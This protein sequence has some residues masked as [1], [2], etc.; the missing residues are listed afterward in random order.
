MV[1]EKYTEFIDD[2]TLQVKNNIIPMSRIDDA[3]KRILRVKFVMGLFENPL[4]DTSLVKELGSQ[5]HR[6]LAKEA[7]RKS[8]VLLKNG[9]P[10]AKPLLPL[11]KKAP[12]ILVAGSHA[13]NLG[14]QCGGWTIQWQGVSGNDVTSGM[15]FYIYISHFYIKHFTHLDDIQ[16]W[17][18]TEN[19]P[20]HQRCGCSYGTQVICSRC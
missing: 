12:K 6:E 1:P 10:G 4:A 7:V 19:Y 15:Y 18:I 8:L 14:Y 2:L 5:E 9:K 16:L 13:D 20:C 17:K 3:V 11:S